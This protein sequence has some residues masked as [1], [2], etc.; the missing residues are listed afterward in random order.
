MLL[1]VEVPPIVILNFHCCLHFQFQMIS[2]LFQWMHSFRPQLLEFHQWEEVGRFGVLILHLWLYL[3]YQASLWINLMHGKRDLILSR[4]NDWLVSRPRQRAAEMVHPHILQ[5]VWTLAQLLLKLQRWC[6]IRGRSLIEVQLFLQRL[7]EELT[8]RLN[9]NKLVLA[10]ANALV[11]FLDCKLLH[12]AC[13][14]QFL[15]DWLCWLCLHEDLLELLQR[16]LKLGRRPVRIFEF[17]QAVR[18]L[19]YDG[20]LRGWLFVRCRLIALDLIC[21]RFEQ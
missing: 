15:A 4:W 2:S 20:D 6:R 17:I 7:G 11:G 19:E 3:S 1:I 14:L 8:V 13:L 18:R 16:D 9:L 10:T 12:F 5:V 21:R